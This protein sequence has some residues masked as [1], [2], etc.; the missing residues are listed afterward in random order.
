MLNVERARDAKERE[1]DERAQAELISAAGIKLIDAEGAE[2]FGLLLVNG[3]PGPIYNV[4]VESQWLNGSK[5][6]PPLNLG[7]LPSG[8][9]VVGPD[10]KYH[11]GQLQDSNNLPSNVRLEILTRG[12]AAEMIT[13]IDFLDA[14]RRLWHLHGVDLQRMSSSEG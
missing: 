13:G 2:R 5:K 1:A 14:H 12:K 4:R 6:N 7:F 3:S 11:W 9:W 10:E 8:S